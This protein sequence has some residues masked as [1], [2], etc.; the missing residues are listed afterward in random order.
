MSSEIQLLEIP[1]PFSLPIQLTCKGVRLGYSRSQGGYKAG[2]ILSN[3][4]L[5]IK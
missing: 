1:V 4:G 3:W 2:K 5:Q